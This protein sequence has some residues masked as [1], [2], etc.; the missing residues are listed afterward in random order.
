[1]GIHT[2][3]NKHQSDFDLDMMLERM[4]NM[5]EDSLNNCADQYSEEDEKEKRPIEEGCVIETAN[6]GVEKT[7]LCDRLTVT[8]PTEQVD[9]EKIFVAPTTC[10]VNVLPGNTCKAPIYA[11]KYIRGIAA[12]V[13]AT[14]QLNMPRREAEDTGGRDDLETHKRGRKHW[15]WQND[16]PDA[17]Y[18][19]PSYS[20][21]G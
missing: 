2:E 4:R 3:G 8:T 10:I 9:S 7:A 21:P 5:I 18:G 20:F 13:Q 1:M 12:D 19:P 6:I 16:P 17:D 14:E 11:W 15:P